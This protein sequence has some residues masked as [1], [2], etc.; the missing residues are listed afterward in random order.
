MQSHPGTSYRDRSVATK[1]CG[2][3]T[4]ADAFAAVDAGAEM[5][6]F[7]FYSGSRRV[8]APAEAATIIRAVRKRGRAECVGVFVDATVEEIRETVERSGI[9]CVQ[10]HGNETP[11]Y[12]ER[13][14]PLS[15][16]KA[17]RVHA[18]FDPG[19]VDAFKCDTILLD[20]WHPNERGG[21]GAVFDWDVA[22]EIRG[23]VARLILA[24]GLNVQNVAAAIRKVR[25]DAVD[26]CSGVEDNARRKNAQRISEFIAAV[27]K[28]TVA[29]ASEVAQRRT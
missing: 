8:I 25:P 7:N 21:T 28:A 17:L 6:G 18:G 5:L 27:R 16:I 12:C 4:A 19:T 29:D 13:L 24:G 9:D 23:R 10:L 14:R 1:I 15:V 20:T 3:T 22:A 2:I 11:D 26:V